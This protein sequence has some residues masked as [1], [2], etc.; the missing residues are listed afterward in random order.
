MG[1]YSVCDAISTVKPFTSA[2]KS[3]AE[4][5]KL[6]VLTKSGNA[7]KYADWAA[8]WASCHEGGA[9][10]AGVSIAG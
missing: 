6:D 8:K 10:G 4:A 9:Y 2:G 3:V 1:T 5:F 7:L